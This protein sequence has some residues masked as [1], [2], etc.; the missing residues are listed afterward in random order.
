MKDQVNHPDHYTQ[1]GIECIEAIKASMS[2]EAFRGYLKGNII[3]YLWRYEH[4]GKAKQDLEKARWY[5]NKLIECLECLEPSDFLD[6][7][8]EDLDEEAVEKAV[9][10]ARD[11]KKKFMEEWSEAQDYFERSETVVEEP[12]TGWCE[13]EWISQK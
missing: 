7:I 4:K 2:E 8:I 10:K 12:N 6:E 1:G 3:K 5:Q 9:E 11:R 13:K